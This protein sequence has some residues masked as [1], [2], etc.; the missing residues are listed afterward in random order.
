MGIFVLSFDFFSLGLKRFRCVFNFFLVKFKLRNLYPLRHIRRM[1]SRSTCT[2]SKSRFFSGVSGVVATFSKFFRPL[3]ARNN[4]IINS[5]RPNARK[6]D[7]GG[8]DRISSQWQKTNVRHWS[9]RKK[10][11]TKIRLHTPVLR[12]PVFFFTSMMGKFIQSKP[13]SSI[14]KR[15]NL[16]DDGISFFARGRNGETEEIVVISFLNG[17]HT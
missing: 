17:T 4:Q 9:A 13:R 1:S 7:L 3:P 14:H 6:V 12:R 5:P 2:T 11:K 10:G 16:F 8:N 15:G